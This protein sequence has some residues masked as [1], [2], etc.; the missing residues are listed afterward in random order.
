MKP[1]P[2]PAL[3]GIADD[4][5]ALLE[6]NGPELDALLADLRSQGAT[7]TSMEVRCVGRWRLRLAWPSH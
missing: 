2:Q 1:N 7:I 5:P 4:Q 3:P 6:C